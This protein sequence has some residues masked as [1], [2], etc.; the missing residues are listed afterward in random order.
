MST[1]TL[2]HQDPAPLLAG[3]PA[4]AEFVHRHQLTGPGSLAQR[5]AALSEDQLADIV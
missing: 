4:L 5:L 2:W 1:D 3:A